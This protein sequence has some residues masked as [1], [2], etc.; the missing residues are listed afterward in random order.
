MSGYSRDYSVVAS[1]SMKEVL[2][3]VAVL[4]DR[5]KHL[6]THQRKITL[7]L[8]GTRSKLSSRL[9]ELQNFPALISRLPDEILLYIFELAV[10]SQSTT[11]SRHVGQLVETILSRVSRYW[12]IIAFRS[13]R[14]WARLIVTPDI[15]TDD[16]DIHFKRSRGRA[17]DV[18][19]VG[20][21]DYMHS[22]LKPQ[23]FDHILNTLLVSAHRWRTIT[24][25]DMCDS[26]LTCLNHRL[27]D[28]P[29]VKLPMLKRITFRAQ[30]PEQSFYLSCLMNQSLENLDAE[31]LSFPAT[32]AISRP[33]VLNTTALTHLTLRVRDGT[34]ARKGIDFS[35]FRL[36]SS[37]APN[38]G[39]LALHGQP[40]S[41]ANRN[42]PETDTA[43]ELPGLRTLVLHPGT[44]TPHYLRDFIAAIKAPSLRRFELIFPD[45]EAPGEDIS[46]LLVEPKSAKSIFPCL[47]TASLQNAA[48]G[49]TAG[50]FAFAFQT[51]TQLQL[52]GS[53]TTAV[54]VHCLKSSTP[55]NNAH[56]DT[57]RL[58]LEEL[59]LS[60][61]SSAT[62]H[63]LHAWA[64]ARHENGQP[65]PRMVIQGPLR[66]DLLFPDLCNAL[67]KH[68]HVVLVDVAM[69]SFKEYLKFTVG[70]LLPGL[71]QASLSVYGQHNAQPGCGQGD[72]DHG[73]GDVC[74]QGPN[75]RAVEGPFTVPRV[76]PYL[77]ATES[78]AKKEAR[79][80]PFET[81]YTPHPDIQARVKICLDHQ[82]LADHGAQG[83]VVNAPIAHRRNSLHSANG[84]TRF[85]ME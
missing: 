75:M 33:N 67:R 11:S 29:T 18:E 4:E 34:P 20:W 9:R 69:S 44:L 52:A 42:S 22:F 24:V 58:N 50:R 78:S 38:L 64:R 8:A 15:H 54:L 45:H 63:H 27:Y 74:A 3:D 83:W 65:V 31:N 55:S 16:I 73:A 82:H 62:L 43:L 49:N 35:L 79:N 76:T 36:L 77:H 85:K 5:E 68:T 53:G 46:D 10:Y 40:I 71:R 59:T 41:V 32:L 6:L 12:R 25:S 81:G 56:Q 48:R 70:A 1:H 47:S 51:L 66:N 2:T 72:E 21:R 14:L 28:Y 37:R 84:Q 7:S 23:H 61:P 26:L 17:L 13:P 30:R 57:P 80:I 60:S 39:H 19:F